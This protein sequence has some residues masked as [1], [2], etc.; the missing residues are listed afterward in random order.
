MVGTN[1]NDVLQGGVEDD[2]LQALGGDDTLDGGGGTNRLE[3]GAGNDTFFV[4]SSTDT[5]VENAGEGTDI[6][7]WSGAG[8]YLLPDNI[9]DLTLEA[10]AS[11][12]TGNALDNT[13]F[14][15]INVDNGVSVTLDGGAGADS[16]W[17]GANDDTIFGGD[18]DDYLDGAGG[19]DDI[20]GGAGNDHIRGESFSFGVGWDDTL[21]GDAGDDLLFGLDGN[22]VLYGGDG[23]DILDGYAGDDMMNGGAGADWFQVDVG[24]NGLDRDVVEDFSDGEDQILLALDGLTAPDMSFVELDHAGRRRYRRRLHERRGDAVARRVGRHHHVG[25]LLLLS[26]RLL[27]C[28]R[29]WRAAPSRTCSGAKAATTGCRAPAPTI[30]STGGDGQ[31]TLQAGSGNDLLDGGTGG[32]TLLGGAGADSLEGGAN[33]DV[34]AGGRGQDTFVF[35]LGSDVDRVVGFKDAWRCSGR[36]DRCFRP[37]ASRRQTRSTHR[38]P[39]TTWS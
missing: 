33:E 38:S 19:G 20:H 11:E 1:G 9:E 13:I 14:A 10:G 27:R 25:R 28:P 29:R 34:L 21:F 31:D 2:L 17:G 8:A 3:G 4:H 12:A 32:D 6:V 23:N 5:A 18:G 24:T 37:T 16:V 36:F 22:D 30:S 35:E 15:N 26:G 7:F 39:A